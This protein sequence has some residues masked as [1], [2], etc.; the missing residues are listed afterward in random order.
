MR[1]VYASG[2]QGPVREVHGGSGYL[3]QD[4][5]IQILGA[6]EPV[7]ALWIRWPGGKVQHVAIPEGTTYIDVKRE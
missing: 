7:S 3:S 4:S 1:L 5:A 2:K 6:A